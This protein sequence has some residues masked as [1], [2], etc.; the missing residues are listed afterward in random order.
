MLHLVV[1]SLVFSNLEQFFI[2][3]ELNFF[4]FKENRLGSL[5]LGLYCF[6]K[7]IAELTL[8][9]SVSYQEA[10]HVDLSYYYGVNFLLLG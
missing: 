8:V 7:N 5:N 4:F 2:F 6:C 3:H 9:F 10:Q 1:K